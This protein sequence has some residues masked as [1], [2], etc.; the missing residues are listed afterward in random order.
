MGAYA[1]N[2]IAYDR[3][4]SHIVA[5]R[6][7]HTH[8]RR[9]PNTHMYWYKYVDFRFPAPPAMRPCLPAPRVRVRSVLGFAAPLTPPSRCGRRRTTAA[10][11]PSPSRGASASWPAPAPGRPAHWRPSPGGRPCRSCR[12][13]FACAAAPSESPRACSRHGAVRFGVRGITTAQRTRENGGDTRAEPGG[14]GG[15]IVRWVGGGRPNGRSNEHNTRTHA[16][17]SRRERKSR[18]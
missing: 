5:Y 10:R 13:A 1:C 9:R 12:P 15:G 11:R 3:I 4:S 8:A 2:M 18:D 16:N 14:T 17:T 7:I 6:R